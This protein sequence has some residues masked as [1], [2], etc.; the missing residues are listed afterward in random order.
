MAMARM[1]MTGCGLV[2]DFPSGGPARQDHLLSL[3]I[4]GHGLSAA[5]LL[6]NRKPPE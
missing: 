5:P 2:R 4:E 6:R 1:V 3:A